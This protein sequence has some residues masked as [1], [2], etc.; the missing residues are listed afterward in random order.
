MKD[1]L[2]RI[3][4]LLLVIIMVALVFLTLYFALTGSP[5]FTASMISMF[6]LP[7]LVYAYMFIYRLLHKDEK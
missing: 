4:A 1:K 2:K 6:M 5:Y 3:F 7:I